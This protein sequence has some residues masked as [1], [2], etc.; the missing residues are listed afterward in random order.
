LETGDGITELDMP[1][2][3][4]TAVGGFDGVATATRAT[5][6]VPAGTSAWELSVESGAQA[7]ADSDYGK[8]KTGP[9]GREASEVTYVEA[10]LAV[11]QKSRTWASARNKEGRW[12]EVRAYNLDQLHIWL[13][14][15]PATMA[16]LAD[17]LGKSMPG[18]QSIQSWWE[19]AWLPSTTPPL[20]ASMV[21][22][23]REAEASAFLARLDHG[24][25]V[26]A[27]G[28]DLRFEEARAFVAAAMKE[29]GKT[30]LTAKAAR[31]LSVTDAGSLAQLAAQPQP[32]VLL[33]SDAALAADLPAQSPHQ[34]VVLA[35]PGSDGD[36]LVPPINAQLLE[37]H[38]KAAGIPN[39]KA[40]QLGALGRRSLLA[41]RRALA[42]TPVLWTPAWASQ[43]DV[44]RRRLLL[45][46]AWEGSNQE[47]RRIVE[48]C[49]GRSYDEIQEAAFQLS[50]APDTPFLGRVEEQWHLLSPEDAWTLL[51]GRLTPDDLAAFRDA[52]Q[53]VLGE[54]DPVLKLAPEERW[55]A[56]LQGV[57]RKFS[58]T[59]RSAL[60]QSLALLGAGEG[61]VQAPRGLT[62]REWALVL[63]RDLLE[64]ANQDESFELWTSL[65]DVLPLLAEAAPTQFMQAMAE[66]LARTPLL[67]QK[68]FTDQG[69]D[70]LGSPSPSVHT[71]FLWAI[72]V[73][74][75][76]PDYFD[77]A[78][79]ILAQLSALDPGGEWSN[80]PIGSLAGILS[81]WCPNTTASWEQRERALHRL[82]RDS[83][84]VARTLL[85]DL[86]PDAHGFQMSHPEPRF[87]DWKHEGPLATAQVGQA[88]EAV[89]GLLLDD[90][91]ASPDRL[92]A[93]LAKI[94]HLSPAHRRRLC[95]GLIDLGASLSDET[96][97][98]DLYYAIREK[99]AHHREY[100]DTYW[101]L[102]E[103]DL[104]LLDAAATAIEP[105]SAVRRNAWLFVSDWIELGDLRRRDDFAAYE[106]ELNH[107]RATAIGE[108][109][110]DGDL[111]AVA[112]LANTTDR[113]M[114]VGTALA[115]HTD[116]F[117]REMVA[118][119]EE[120]E[121]PRVDVA[122]AYLAQRLRTGR[123]DLLVDLL[124]QTE[125]PRTQ[126]RVL[127]A[128]FDPPTAWQ[129]LLELSEAV[130]EHYWKEFSYFGLGASF[131]HVLVV[132]R[133][134]LDVGRHAATLDLLALYNRH[135]ESQEAAEL[136]LEAFEGLIAG[137]LADPEMPRLSRHE[138][139]VLFSL[140]A[141]HRDALGLQR[142]VHV[143]WQLFPTLGFQADAPTLHAALAEDPAFF[144]ELV[145]YCFRRDTADEDFSG[146]DEEREIR[147]R[148]ASR[149]SE[150]LLT[151][152][153]PPGID[154]NGTVDLAK[155]R[156]WVT[157]AR[158]R[159]MHDDRL[160][161]GDS[162]IG[163]ILAF[164]PPDPDGMF[165]PRAVR[166]LLEEIRSDRLD[167]GLG[168]GIYNKRGVTSRGVF[169]GGESEK[170]LADEYRAA[171][172]DAKAWPRT[173]RR[174]L[175]LAESY[176]HDA[177]RNEVEAERRRRGLDD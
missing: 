140:L 28:G 81:C 36:V 145:G 117:D 11:W 87:R 3:S 51:G 168:V 91:D 112:D 27:L 8:R 82:L 23:G 24:P 62:G 17:Q 100:A 128:T 156:D 26:I 176:E 49:V 159:L 177:R 113:P 50:G 83:P 70:A 150:V 167:K 107:R 92:L 46:G 67:Y 163:H 124:G 20:N 61:A 135:T 155:L 18:V 94:D 40:G 146:T 97:R 34:L 106:D 126:A 25:G 109:L 54:R 138:L 143:E 153:R 115:E 37:S 151:W 123:G 175:E 139:E 148:M 171:A 80:R 75:W 42:V 129:K 33:L 130:S 5:T 86:I 136:A 121:A 119:L 2:E 78:V 160:G 69:R 88:V 58:R 7:K 157:H 96:A 142:V 77:D 152:R 53:E 118:W 72:E 99:A 66:G 108:V 164:T 162:Q 56:G 141:Q 30:G 45:L 59:L 103:D 90:L 44:I 174:L 19:A 52:V 41:L 65:G 132:A 10:I 76:S 154:E 84:D 29:V 131:A 133:S 74:A 169:D 57:R 47:D 165:P 161:S 63:V 21:L 55:R 166:D 147:S 120:N 116:A 12:K 170:D 111:N 104:Q 38:L 85:I 79:D 98:A 15:A 125:D 16:W 114:L 35:A 158:E 32:L 71:N 149:A 1:G 89:V 110:Q 22:A 95:D 13:D 68:M 101:A 137:G 144:A 64:N 9:E 105:R 172:E 173:R 39:D 102:P 60:A 6:F 122:F 73:L 31:T 127:R 93:L 48:S 14:S 134:L 43:P 4:G